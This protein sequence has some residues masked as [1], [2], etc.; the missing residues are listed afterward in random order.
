MEPKDSLPCSQQLASGLCSDPDEFS[1]HL[2]NL[3][4]K[5]H[6]NIMP[7]I[8]FHNAEGRIFD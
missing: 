7:I 8:W 5:I 2:H 6:F 3:F 1:P 4:I